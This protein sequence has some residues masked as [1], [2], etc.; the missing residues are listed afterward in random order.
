MTT[1]TTAVSQVTTAP[2]GRRRLVKYGV[3]LIIALLARVAFRLSGALAAGP[4][5]A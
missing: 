1:S 2:R 5:A 3:A 4:L